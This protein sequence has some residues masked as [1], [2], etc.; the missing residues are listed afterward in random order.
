MKSWRSGIG[1]SPEHCLVALQPWQGEEKKGFCWEPHIGSKSRGSQETICGV[2]LGCHSLESKAGCQI[3]SKA[4]D[5]VQR[6]PWFHVWHWVPP[7][8]GW[9]WAARP[10]WSDLVWKQIG[11]LRWGCWRNGRISHH[12]LFP[13]FSLFIPCWNFH[14]N[15]KHPTH[16]F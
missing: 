16:T 9:V 4:W 5:Y 13:Y 7:S 2:G 6:W 12:S 15:G 14:M 3:V 10:R 8:I 1:L 11:D